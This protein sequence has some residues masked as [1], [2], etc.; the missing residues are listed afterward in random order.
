MKFIFILSGLLTGTVFGLAPGLKNSWKNRQIV[1]LSLAMAL[2]IYL[3]F[4]PETAMTP[5]QLK[6]FAAKDI[7]NNKNVHFSVS[8]SSDN[9]YIIT[10]ISNK[11]NRYMLKANNLNFAKGDEVI[12]VLRYKAHEDVFSL[13][14]A[15]SVN[16]LLVLPFVPALGENIRILNLHVPCA[17]IAVLAFLI[18]MI[19]SVLYLSRKRLFY[20]IASSSSALIGFIFTILATTTGML[21]AKDNWGE[22]WNWDP[23]ETSIFVLL[24]IYMAYFALRSSLENKQIKARF[25]A[26]Y[27]ILAFATVP[28]L[29]FILPRISIGLHPGSADDINTGPLLSYNED[30][31]NYLKQISFSL[32]FMSYTMLYFFLLNILVRFKYLSHFINNT[33]L[34][35]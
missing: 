28:F 31:L 10:D 16:P 33:S 18:S 35:D 15:V 11:S 6:Y 19:Y 7:Y 24:L 13:V 12:A 27:S 9:T 14:E 20:D 17:W 26:V 30:S 1:I 5:S 8:N 21:W 4:A 29:I 3:T 23:R 22:Y 32:S 25:S 2:S 34:I